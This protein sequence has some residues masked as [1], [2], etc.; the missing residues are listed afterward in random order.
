MP[1]I[2]IIFAAPA[3]QSSMPIAIIMSLTVIILIYLTTSFAEHYA[4]S[5]YNVTNSN[6]LD[7]QHY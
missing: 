7:R 1:L 6:Y 3:L 4:N 5:Y 2:V